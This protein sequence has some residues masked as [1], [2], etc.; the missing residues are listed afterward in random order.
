MKP[1]NPTDCFASANRG[2]DFTDGLGLAV[3]TLEKR[4]RA[5]VA[6]RLPRGYKLKERLPTDDLE[7]YASSE[8]KRIVCPPLID[9]FALGV[10]LHEVGHVVLG[11]LRSDD[12]PGW[13][14]E[15]EAEQWAMKAMRA[16]GFR[17]S[18]EFAGRARHNVRCCIEKALDKEP[19]CVID[20][21]V[22][23]FAFPDTWRE[24]A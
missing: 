4:I 2:N 5:V 7:G 21:E 8:P 24:A 22:L 18:D 19:D 11:H 1:Q 3:G 17:V 20:E 12:L 6:K 9:R 14:E 13:R 16:E 23:R 15:Y 10:F